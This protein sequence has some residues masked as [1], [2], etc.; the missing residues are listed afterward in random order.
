MLDLKLRK[1]WN[2]PKPVY[3]KLDPTNALYP[4]YMRNW[5]QLAAGRAAVEDT[6]GA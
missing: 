5:A 4:G 3:D 2:K 6:T 1:E